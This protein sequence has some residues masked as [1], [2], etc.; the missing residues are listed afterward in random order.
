MAKIA[1]NERTDRMELAI[2]SQLERE[3]IRAG[4]KSGQGNVPR[5]K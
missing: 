4:A 3:A 1:A 5:R 2:E